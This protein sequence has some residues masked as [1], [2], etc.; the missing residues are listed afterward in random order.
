MSPD[1]SPETATTSGGRGGA[2]VALTATPAPAAENGSTP[3]T[4]RAGAPDLSNGPASPCGPSAEAA[5]PATSGAASTD[6]ADWPVPGGWFYTQGAGPGGGGYAIV[7][8]QQARFW[9]HFQALGGW[10]VLGFPVSGRFT[11]DGKLTQATQ[12]ALLQWSPEGGQVALAN[13]LDLLHERE[14]DAALLGQHQ[15]PPPTT[16]NQVNQD[17]ATIA[18]TRLSW[19]DA[20][21]AIKQKYCEAPGGADPLALWG[22]P[23]SEAIDVSGTGAVYVMRTQRAAF[24]EWVEGLS[25]DGQT[26]AAPGEVTVVLAGDLAKNLGLIP[27]TALIPESAPAAPTQPAPGSILYC[28]EF[29]NPAQSQS[30]KPPESDPGH[31][32][33][34]VESGEYVI[35]KTDPSWDGLPTAV[36]PGDYA[37]ASLSVAARLVG[38]TKGRF[39]AIACRDAAEV[40][41]YRF[42]V[43]PDTGRFQ[44]SR[45]GADG[46]ATALAGGETPGAIL[47]GSATNRLAL[48]CAGDSISASVNDVQ[49]ASI[50]DP[51][52]GAPV[53]GMWIGVGTAGGATSGVNGGPTGP[54]NATVEARFD[55]L[56]VRQQ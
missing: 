48:T 7:D 49:V 27:C 46:D 45:V 9:S 42:S 40:G 23:T 11:L 33:A 52:G 29:E 37:D 26:I 34:V 13:V 24:Q 4:T 54:S 8:D 36:L 14:R 50:S 20:R 15:I 35:R 2:L 44:L 47:P 1:T 28:D 53:G 25:I 22:L 31:Y 38:D 32:T 51:G 16:L 55:S 18:A 3:A 21:P 56:V 10:R 41:Y 12:R 39:V 19:L 6:G 17:F 43:E 30:P 5:A